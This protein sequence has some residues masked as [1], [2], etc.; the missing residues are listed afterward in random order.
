ML[1]PH[2]RNDT[3]MEF[4]VNGITADQSAEKRARLILLGESLP[5][6]DHRSDTFF[7]SHL[8]RGTGDEGV[9]EAVLPQFWSMHHAKPMEFLRLARIQAVF[10]L[11]VTHTVEHILAL[12]LGPIAKGSVHVHFEGR[13]RQEYTNR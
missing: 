13:R 2:R 11:K 10:A 4:T 12:T 3:T 5:T 9:L 1:R 6:G 7:L 8:G